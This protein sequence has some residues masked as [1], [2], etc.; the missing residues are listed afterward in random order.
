MDTEFGRKDTEEMDE[1]EKEKTSSDVEKK[2]I[3]GNGRE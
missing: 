2:R 1:E 3:R